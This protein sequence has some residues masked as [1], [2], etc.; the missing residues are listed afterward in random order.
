MGHLVD[1]LFVYCRRV[2]KA[3][4]SG[5]GVVDEMERTS[6]TNDLTGPRALMDI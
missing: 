6:R 2:N 3:S 4:C 5:A 1:V